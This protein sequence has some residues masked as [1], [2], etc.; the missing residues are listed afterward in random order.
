LLQG[1]RGRWLRAVLVVLGVAILGCAA[2]ASGA[3]ASVRHFERVTP[4]DKGDGDIVAEGEAIVAAKSGGGVAFDSR[5]AFGD[6]IG[7]GVV[8]RTTYVASRAA[9][10]AW[11]THAITPTPRP[12]TNQVLFAKN[13]IQVFSDDLSTAIAWAYDLPA[14]SDDTPKRM[15]LYVEDTA[16]RTFRPVSVS[17]VDPL[18]PNEFLDPFA[19]PILGVSD[20]AKHLAFASFTQMLP[21]AAP[22]TQNVYKWDDGV[23]SVVKM[24]HGRAPS[25]GSSVVPS[26]VRNTMSPDGTRLAFM[27]TDDGSDPAAQLYMHIDGSRTAWVSEPE[28][29]SWRDGSDRT[30]PENVFFE[31]MT[32]DGK[33]VFFVSNSALLDE[34]DTPGADLYRYTDSPNPAS[35]DNL[36]LITHT[37]GAVNDPP[38]FGGSLVGMSDDAGTVYVHDI[39]GFLTVWNDGVTDVVDPSAPR[40]PDLRR[41]L[42]LTS[43]QPGG[44]RVSP[45]G[46]WLAYVKDSRMYVYDLRRDELACV[47]CPGDASLVPKLTNAGALD[48]TTFRPRFLSDNGRVF[49][50]STGALVPQDINGVAD[51]YEYDAP[52]RTISLLS[53]GKSTF[54]SN[55]ADASASGDDVFIVTRNRLVPDDRDNYIDLYDV[56]VGPGA[57]AS[58]DSAPACEGDACQG[59]PSTEPADDTL[60]SLTFEGGQGG[61]TSIGRLNVRH[62]ATI[63][64]SRGVLRVKLTAAGRL[65]WSGRGLVAGSLRRGSAGTAKVRVRL[66]HRAQTR[67]RRSGHYRTTVHLTFLAADGTKATGSIRVTFRAVAKK[68]R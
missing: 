6:A 13:T 24:P 64:G 10:G 33:N 32:P 8:G 31:G 49:F 30:L 14:V 39:G 4:A 9:E 40:E 59:A 2:F 60:G 16:T 57:P 28:R 19:T 67:L 52:A 5:L 61:G 47:S 44:G 27:S 55:F 41:A 43:V 62:R 36:T 56:R 1:E 65:K 54:A 26:G 21:D 53:P 23:L 68:G 35:D 37:G 48:D 50:T 29:S 12:E 17:Q 63:H 7:S 42:S 51:V 22:F 66:G 38:V 25:A 3:G 15:N 46:N 11:T 34:D 45:D 18:S 20:D 58:A